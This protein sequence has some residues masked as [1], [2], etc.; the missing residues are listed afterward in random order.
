MR[1]GVKIKIPRPFLKI[2]EMSFCIFIKIVSNFIKRN[3]ILKDLGIP[4]L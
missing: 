3:P 4:N 1:K 2:F